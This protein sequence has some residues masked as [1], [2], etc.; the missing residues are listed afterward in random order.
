M[1]VDVQEAELA[2]LA[3]HDDDEGVKVVDN[4]RHVEKPEAERQPGALLNDR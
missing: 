3:P 1:V 4:F 2:P